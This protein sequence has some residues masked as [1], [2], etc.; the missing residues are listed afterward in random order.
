M[1]RLLGGL[2]IYLS[3]LYCGPRGRGGGGRGRE[4]TGLY[5]ELAVLGFNE[6]ASAALISLVGRQCSLLPSYELAR[7]ELAGRGM[8]LNIKVVHRL[9]RTL[10]AQAL[11]ARRRALEEWRGARRAVG[12]G[13]GRHQ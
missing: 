10:G 8:P 11:T 4:G 7:Q 9:A 13:V 1:V 3:T 12:A 6:G 2:V 5:P